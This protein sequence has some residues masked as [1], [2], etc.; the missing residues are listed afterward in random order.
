ME[1]I[2]IKEEVIDE[3]EFETHPVTNTGDWGGLPV[4]VNVKEK[5]DFHE[6]L[7]MDLKRETFAKKYAIGDKDEGEVSYS[8]ER[9][10]QDSKPN[11][12]NKD[13]P[14]VAQRDRDMSIEDEIFRCDECEYK[15]KRKFRLEEHRRKHINDLFQCSEC[16]FAEPGA[17]AIADFPIPIVL[18]PSSSIKSRCPF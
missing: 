17:M 12:E 1:C 16:N 4:G 6:E 7:E 5:I 3:N 11:V 13:V 15:T 18:E 2:Y 10:K 9:F 8:K 14:L